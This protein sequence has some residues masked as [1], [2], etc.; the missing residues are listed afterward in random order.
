V[1]GE[2]PSIR[3]TVDLNQPLPNAGTGARSGSTWNSIRRR[4]SA[5]CGIWASNREFF[6]VSQEGPMRKARTAVLS[7]FPWCRSA[8]VEAQRWSS[9][10]R[11]RTCRRLTDATS[12]TTDSSWCARWYARGPI[13][14]HPVADLA[15]RD[16]GFDVLTRVHVSQ[17][18]YHPA[19]RKLA[20]VE[21]DRS[22]PGEDTV[23]VNR[24]RE[25]G[26]FEKVLSGRPKNRGKVLRY[27]YL[28]FDFSSVTKPGM[29]LIDYGHFRTQTFRIASAG[30]GSRCRSICCHCKCVTCGWR[31]NIVSGTAR[32]IW[33][34]RAW[35]R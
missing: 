33:R 18:G 32:V 1:R 10:A 17:V 21:I 11:P 23:S 31:S 27:K 28:Q 16:S 9:K 35:R 29:K 25:N 22:D 24:V 26:G 20:I 30:C 13:R 5:R 34:T 15:P 8:E 2:G 3:V 19:Q 4:C 7:Q 6:H 12:T 14:E